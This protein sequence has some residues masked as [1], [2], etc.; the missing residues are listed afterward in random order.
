MN[1]ELLFFFKS[2]AWGVI[3]LFFYDLLRIGRRLFPRRALWVSLEDLAYWSLAGVFLFGKMYQANEGKIRGYSV[4]AVMLGMALYSYG[5]SGAFVSTAVKIL[6]IP[7][8]FL[9]SVE[10]RLLFAVR[11]C[12]ILVSK[13]LRA[14]WKKAVRR[15]GKLKRGKKVEKK[16]TDK[17]Q[18]KK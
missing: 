17:A 10:K 1:H 8:K 6:E 15:L 7:L 3:L 9:I 11:H 2:I 5:V 4:I 16:S 12:K 13:K 18:K 14:A